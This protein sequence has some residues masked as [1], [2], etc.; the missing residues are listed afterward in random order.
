[1][2]I[3]AEPRDRI[4]RVAVYCGSS[5]G[6]DSRYRQLSYD[7]GQ[8]LA[9]AGLGLVYGGGQ[10]GLMGALCEG[11]LSHAGEIIGVIPRFLQA[12]ERA[13]TD[14]RIDL[15]IVATMEER[16]ALY[17]S[18]ADAFVALP[19]RATEHSKSSSKCLPA[20]I[21]GSFAV[22][23]MLLTP[24][25]LLRWRPCTARRRSRGRFHQPKATGHGLHRI[26]GRRCSGAAHGIFL[27]PHRAVAC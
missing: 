22:P 3:D 5:D 15:R 8:A 16:K 7:F 13:N 20:R 18:L 4:R 26:D 27:T 10:V 9:R 6:T 12:K 19:G 24:D 2:I 21:S 17:Y 23:L 1:M 14:E 11:A 25:G